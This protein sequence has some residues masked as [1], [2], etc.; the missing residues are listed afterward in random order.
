M[1]GVCVRLFC[2]CVVLYLG[3]GL[4]TDRSL[5]QEVLPPVYRS[6]EKWNNIRGMN[7]KNKYL[8]C[9]SSVSVCV[10]FVWSL[11][12]SIFFI[13]IHYFRATDFSSIYIV[14]KYI[15]FAAYRSSAKHWFCKQR[16]LLCNARNNRAIGLCKPFLSVGSVNTPTTIGVLLET[17]FYSVRAKWL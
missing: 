16:P 5:V 1:F 13:R 6:K 12:L 11:V 10:W 9:S 2:I 15:H 7:I 14:Y 8:Q 17:V 3:T 4:A